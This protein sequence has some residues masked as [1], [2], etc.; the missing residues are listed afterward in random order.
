MPFY[1]TQTMS[2]GTLPTKLY[3]RAQTQEHVSHDESSRFTQDAKQN[4][5]TFNH[6]VVGNVVEGTYRSG[7]GVPTADNRF[8]I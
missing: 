2:S 6:I 1:M 8:Q 4:Y 7:Q 3:Y 5:A